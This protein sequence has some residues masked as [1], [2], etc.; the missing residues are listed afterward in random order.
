M[1]KA[2]YYI[3][4]NNRTH[5]LELDKIETIISKHFEGFTAFEVI[6]YWR[7]SKERTLKVEVI[8][9]EKDSTLARIGKELMTKLE[10]ESVLLEI[11]ETNA[12][13]IQ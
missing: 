12:A 9:E 1:K 10:Q 6:G 8:T 4:S 5:E 7:G 11:V 2:Y 13:F 3:G